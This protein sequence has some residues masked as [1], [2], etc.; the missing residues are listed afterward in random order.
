MS[1]AT[2]IADYGRFPPFRKN[3]II[4][5]GMAV[6]QRGTTIVSPSNTD[7]TLDRWQW[8]Q[9]GAGAVTVTQ[10]AAQSG[11]SPHWHAM[12]VDVT[13]ADASLAATDIYLI[14]QRIEG[15]MLTDSGWG[16][17]AAKDITLSFKT[18]HTKT[19]TYC[20]SI[21][22]SAL[23]RSYIAEYTQSVA[24]AWETHEIT[25][26]GDT[27]GTW[28]R[29]ADTGIELNFV[30]GAGATSNWVGTA[31]AWT[32]T[33]DLHTANQVNVMDSTSGFFRFT[34]VKLEY[35]SEATE[36]VARP[37]GEELA[38]CQR[39]YQKSY[40]STQYPGTVTSGGSQSYTAQRT[41]TQQYI[42]PAQFAVPMRVTPT[43]V[44]YGTDGTLNRVNGIDSGNLVAGSFALS[45]R[46]IRVITTTTSHVLHDR[47]Q[48]HWT[49]DAEL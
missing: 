27:T 32:A 21:R 3:L 16:A 1:K 20:I 40:Q 33:N 48:F 46:Q 9:V 42:S 44:I 26:P 35:G 31:D 39:Y 29:S 37:F 25:I 6:V 49:A 38:L 12:Y 10:T 45:D 13:T 2:D 41:A 24:S 8:T 7:Y 43:L 47:Y 23:D 22:N 4:N 28:L 14:R 30:I 17:A 15:R 19:G 5:G 34:D 36:F 11:A 18:A